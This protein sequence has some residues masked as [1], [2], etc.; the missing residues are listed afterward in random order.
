VTRSRWTERWYYEV[1]DVAGL[2]PVRPK[3]TGPPCM[4]GAAWLRR[5][6]WTVLRRARPACCWY[7][8]VDWH[9]ASETAVRLARQAQAA[10]IPVE[11]TAEAVAAGG[12]SCELAGADLEAVRALLDV[13]DGIL[14]DD[15][16]PAEPPAVNEGRHRIT[17]MRDT[18]VRRTVTV[19]LEL[20]GVV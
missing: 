11:D 10:G 3:L 15:E 20:T 12:L 2:P 6:R 5:I 18:G 17:A 9:A 19:R 8:R 7:H 16:D 4:T 1:R 13:D 14:I